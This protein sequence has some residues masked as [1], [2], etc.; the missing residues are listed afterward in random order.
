LAKKTPTTTK[1]YGRDYYR[2]G[3]IGE[4]VIT[5]ELPKS[6]GLTVDGKSN[7][8][9]VEPC[10]TVADALNAL[11]KKAPGVLDRIVDERGNLREHVNVFTN[12]ENIRF[13]Q[14]STTP[15]PEG[16]DILILTAISG[17]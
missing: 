10:A 11:G 5:I 6:L 9:I 4:P 2:L 15:T 12:G 16:S 8:E 3:G 17:G 1:A 14:G 13:L 7:V